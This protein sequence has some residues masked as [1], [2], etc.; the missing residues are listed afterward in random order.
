V[1]LA[2][3][4]SVAGQRF[5]GATPELAERPQK[6]RQYVRVPFGRKRIEDH[7]FDSTKVDLVTVSPDGTKAL[8]YVVADRPWTGSDAQITS[9]QEKIHN[10][11]AFAVDGQLHLA[12]PETATLGWGIVIDCQQGAP[13]TRTGAV[14]SQLTEP[15]KR[16][17]GDLVVHS[18]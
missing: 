4:R 11:V 16:Y 7:P 1:P 3:E 8:L 9:L 12:Y 15:L 6:I 5:S 2:K 17:G 14:L 13:D 10:Y 18:A